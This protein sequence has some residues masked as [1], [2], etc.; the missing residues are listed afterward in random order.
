V[1]SGALARRV[2]DWAEDRLIPDAFRAFRSQQPL[3]VRN[4]GSIRPW[5]FVLEPLSGYLLLAER[6]AQGD[7]RW[8]AA[9]NFG[10]EEPAAVS[11]I[12]IAPARETTRYAA[13]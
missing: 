9:W 7:A 3:Q 6:L 8:R 11:A 1:C 13:L 12:A 5:Q 10:V 2:G 4:P